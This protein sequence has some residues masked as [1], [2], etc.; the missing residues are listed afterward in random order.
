MVTIVWQVLG[1][2]HYN[3]SNLEL[4]Q[5]HHIQIISVTIY[6]LCFNGSWSSRRHTNSPTQN[7]KSLVNHLIEWSTR[8]KW[9]HFTDSKVNLPNC[10]T[11]VCCAKCILTFF[12][13]MEAKRLLLRARS[14]VIPSGNEVR[15]SEKNYHEV[16]LCYRHWA[17]LATTEVLDFM[18]CLLSQSSHSAIDVLHFEST[19]WWVD[20]LA[21]WHFMSASWPVGNLTYRLNK[22]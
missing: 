7:V 8:R 20:M 10:Y 11:E 13:R 22:H 21:S 17:L 14:P 15:I 1:S 3:D 2:A 5:T 4:Q 19:C 16:S 6:L 9:S 18:R 12:A